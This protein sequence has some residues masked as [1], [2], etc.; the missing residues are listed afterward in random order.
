MGGAQNQNRHAVIADNP[1]RKQVQGSGWGHYIPGIAGIPD[2]AE[3][4]GRPAFRGLEARSQEGRA[5]GKPEG[6][7]KAAGPG[8]TGETGSARGAHGNVGVTGR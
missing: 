6:R 8:L 4:G 1:V 5:P 3:H 2:R 7:A